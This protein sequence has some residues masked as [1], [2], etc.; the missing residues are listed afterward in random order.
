MAY[1]TKMKNRLRWSKLY[2]KKTKTSSDLEL[3][4][5]PYDGE[6]DDSEGD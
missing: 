4:D 3:M 6:A 1:N 5:M 2:N